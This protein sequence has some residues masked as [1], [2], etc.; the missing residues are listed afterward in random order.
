[1]T[2]Y[3]FVGPIVK[4]GAVITHPMLPS[5]LQCLSVRKAGK[6][7]AKPEVV[8]RVVSDGETFTAPGWFRGTY[9]DVRGEIEKSPSVIPGKQGRNVFVLKLFAH[10]FHV[11][12]FASLLVVWTSGFCLF[13][14]VRFRRK[15][16][17]I[18]GAQVRE[19][20]VSTCSS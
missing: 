3:K 7:L 19:K 16:D 11:L 8:F 12:G 18:A 20:S 1:M 13:M 5:D 15:G 17:D 6:K 2:G 10:R 4:K 14:F 9:Y